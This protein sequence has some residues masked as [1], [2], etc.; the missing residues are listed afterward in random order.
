[1]ALTVILVEEQSS[2]AVIRTLAKRLGIDKNVRIFEHQGVGDLK[3]SL[4]IKMRAITDRNTRFI[5]LRDQ[6]NG[7]CVELKRELQE[8]VPTA[9][10]A[11]T[12]IRIACRE[13]EAWYLAQPD[14]LKRAR[15]LRVELPANL[16]DRNP[17]HVAD[18]KAELLRRTQK[19]GQMWIASLVGPQLDPDN[20]KSASFSIF[21]DTLKAF[22]VA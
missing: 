19:S 12:R 10:K 15:V 2:A 16:I 20:R 4:A 8:L 6:D 9:Q 7:N 14:A 5:V 22:S 3:R 17:D 13:L 1:M 21:V 18:P 11:Q